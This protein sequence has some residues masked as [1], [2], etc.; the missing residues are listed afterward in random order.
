LFARPQRIN[1]L[2]DIVKI[3]ASSDEVTALKADGTVLTWGENDLGQLGYGYSSKI[4]KV[5]Q[6]IDYDGRATDIGDRFLIAENGSIWRWGPEL[7]V[8]GDLRQKRL[9]TSSS[10]SSLF[11][12]VN[13]KHIYATRLG[14]QSPVGFYVD[15]NN[16]L[17]SWGNSGAGIRGDGTHERAKLLFN[18]TRAELR[19]DENKS[20]C[21]KG[22]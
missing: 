17:H 12:F 20:L 2:T 13:A 5:P 22:E 19:E 10:P 18:N 7:L 4:S 6:K 1:A 15:D 3:V 8:F 11:S 9:F 14:N 16:C 21:I